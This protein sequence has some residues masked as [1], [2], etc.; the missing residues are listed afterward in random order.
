M[1]KIGK[2]ARRTFLIG[3]AAVAGGVAVGYYYYQ[4]DPKNPLEDRLAEGEATFNPYIKIAGD[5]S[6]T[7]YTGRSEMGQGVSTTLAAM[8]AEE[9]DV[10]LSQI[11][12]EPG[13]ASSAYRNNA[14]LEE[15]T[16]A[17]PWDEGFAARAERS[18]MGVIA[19]IIGAQATGGSSS[20]R[21]GYDKMRA[22]GAAAREMIRLVAARRMGVS[23]GSL[24]TEGGVVSSGGQ[25][26]TYGELAADAAAVEPPRKIRLREPKDWRLLGGSQPRTDIPAKVTGKAV[27]GIDIEL[28]DMVHATVRIAPRFGA[29]VVSYDD[30]AALEVPGVEKVVRIDV[31]DTHGF[32]V[33]ASNTWAAFKGAEAIEVEWE[34]AGYALTHDA[35]MDDFRAKLD[36]EDGSIFRTVGD[37]KAAFADAAPADRVEAEYTVPFLAHACMEPMNATAQ[38]KDGKLTIWAPTQAPGLAAM[39]AGAVTD[40]D[41]DTIEV[42]TTYL[43]GGFGRRAE[44]DYVRY[45]AAMAT[46]TDGRPVKVTWNREEDTRHDMYRPAAVA[47]M[48]AVARKGEAPAA[49]LAKVAAPSIMQ[50]VMGRTLFAPSSPSPDRA[51]VEGIFDQP[52]DFDAVAVNAVHPA[53]T[54][55]IGFWRS[56]GNSHNGFFHETF[57]DEVAHHSGVDPVE[58][59]LRMMANYPTAQKCV[60][61]VAEMSGWGRSLPEGQGMGL[62][63]VYSFGSWVAEVAK[64]TVTDDGVKMD[65]VWCAADVGRALDP[66]IVAAQMQSGVI[67]GLSS[68]MNQKIT[69]ADGEV[70]EGNF[71]DFDSMRMAQCPEIEVAVL[72]NAP[73]MGG[74]G[75]PGMPPAP[76]A[77]GNAIFAATGQRLR[78]LPFGD[79]VE[80][81]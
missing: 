77:L 15:A 35:I 66:A 48:Q 32:G 16:M 25:S 61:K 13:P 52:V 62:A 51:T 3:A 28:P 40:I 81:V 44:S 64:V 34:D 67:F 47:R 57:L 2:I 38:L 78:S 65:N 29:N 9:L 45:A 37:P 46:H 39:A 14:M 7:I 1:S 12:V 54:L 56:V 80:F 23:L 53:Q 55:P 5:N 4:R 8:V 11:T 18:S 30:A 74:A 36:A 20:T 31:G 73:K 71:W 72:E 60:E 33:I 42:H 69:L 17:R 10:S 24:K 6:I 70:Q 27:F 43:G 21:D 68:A 26:M 76:P 58:M 50:S 49:F 63:F 19:E 41:R 75:E 22:A 79:E 59:R